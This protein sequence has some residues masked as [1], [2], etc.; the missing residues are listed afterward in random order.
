MALGKRV[1]IKQESEGKAIELALGK[2]VSIKQES[3]C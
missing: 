1:S 3:K 2:R